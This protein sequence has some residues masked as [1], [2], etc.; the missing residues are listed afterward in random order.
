MHARVRAD[1]KQKRKRCAVFS[2]P[3]LKKVP[4]GLK[5]KKKEKKGT[6]A[7]V[8]WIEVEGTKQRG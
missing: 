8:H 4:R 7:P 2:A 3:S 1:I 5:E 6:G